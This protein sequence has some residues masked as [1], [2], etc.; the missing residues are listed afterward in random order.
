MTRHDGRIFKVYNGECNVTFE[1]CELYNQ[2]GNFMNALGP[3]GTGIAPDAI[4]EA[5]FINYE[6][7]KKCF[8][9]IL[10]PHLSNNGTKPI[11]VLG[12]SIVQNYTSEFQVEAQNQDTTVTNT[13]TQGV[14]T[15]TY[16]RT[17][18]LY[19]YLTL[20]HS[21]LVSVRDRQVLHT[22]RTKCMQM[23]L[24]HTLLDVH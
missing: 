21:I 4:P 5:E 18:T 24:V 14:H 23:C 3:N 17:H 6:D 15:Y 9:L 1:C 8:R 7:G 2:Q 20:A 12:K 13:H 10:Y 11:C 22:Q 19:M 16:T